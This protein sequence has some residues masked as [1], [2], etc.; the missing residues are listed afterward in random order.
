MTTDTETLVRRAYHFAE[1]N[2]LDMPGLSSPCLP[3]TER[4]NAVTMTA[5][6]SNWAG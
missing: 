3:R 2:V 4:I 5:E 1:G 6:V